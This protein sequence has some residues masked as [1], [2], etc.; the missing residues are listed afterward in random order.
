M[1]ITVNTSNALT[2][3]LIFAGVAD[4]GSFYDATGNHTLTLNGGMS[5][6]QTA[7]GEALGL[8]SGKYVTIAPTLT[9]NGRSQQGGGTGHTYLFV[10]DIGGAGNNPAFVLNSDYQMQLAGGSSIL[11]ARDISLDNGKGAVTLA[12]NIVVNGSNKVLLM[13]MGDQNVP[14]T[15]VY[16]DGV[17]VLDRATGNDGWSSY[18]ISTILGDNQY[19]TANY[20]ASGSNARRLFIWNRMLSDAEMQAVVANVDGLLTGVPAPAVAPT[21][22]SA[23]ADNLTGGGVYVVVSNPL[24]DWTQASPAHAAPALS[25]FT[26]TGSILGAR[27]FTDIAPDLAE[28]RFRL[29]GVSPAFRAGETLTLSYAAPADGSG[30]YDA[31]GTKAMVSFG[32]VTVASNVVAVAPGAPTIGTAQAGDGYVDVVFTPPAFDGYSNLTGYTATLSTGETN[33]GATSPIRVTAANGTARTAH[34]T[35]SNSSGP[36]AASAESNSVTPQA[37]VVA[38]TI[39]APAAPTNITATAGAAGSGQAMVSFT[40]GSDGGA[41]QGFHV[42]ST[43]AN[44]NAGPTA[45]GSTSPI[46]VTGLTAGVAYTFKVRAINSAG[47]SIA[48]GPSNSIT[49]AAAVVTPLPST[50]K[51]FYY[52]P[53]SFRIKTVGPGKDFNSINDASGWLYMRDLVT[54]GSGVAFVVYD[55]E[56]IPGS[57]LTPKTSND[58]IYALWVPAL[59]LSA[60]ELNASGALD[61]GTQG[62]ELTFNGQVSINAGNMVQGFRIHVPA[63]QGGS[64]GGI[65]LG[66][67][68]WS[69]GGS[70]NPYLDSCRILCESASNNFYT[71]GYGRASSISNCVVIQQTNLG[72]IGDFSSFSAT[73]CTFVRRGGTGTAPLFSNRNIALSNCAFA[74]CGSQLCSDTGGNW[75]FASTNATDTAITAGPSDSFIYGATVANAA[76]DL[77]PASGGVLI[78]AASLGQKYTK[79]VRSHN[80]GSSPDIG[81][82][83][84]ALVPDLVFANV[85]QEIVDGQSI[86]V[87]GTLDRAADSATGFMES[88]S[89]GVVSTGIQSIT[90]DNTALT[91][92]VTFDG[93][94]PGTFLPNFT[95]VNAG[96]PSQA[97]GGVPVT[98]IGMTADTVDSGQAGTGTITPSPTAPTI[99]ITTLDV[100]V[101][102]GGRATLNG[103]VNLQGDVTGAV[104]LTIKPAVGSNQGPFVCNVSNGTWTIQKTGLRPGLYTFEVTA[105]ANG[106]TV[107]ATTGAIRVLGLASTNFN[108]PA[109]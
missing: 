6:A 5:T 60:A 104:T 84:L 18:N 23:V 94:L 62:L 46:A 45:D 43:D 57:G 47:Q 44:G 38:P 109:S 15:R 89:Y 58:Q 29:H 93:V 55:N 27:T 53:P 37:G 3:G 105:S 16:L 85:T 14:G 82:V 13:T 52:I 95:F 69:D 99:S 103:T 74:N 107:K 63:N 100:N 81:A 50:A 49:V 61:Y 2:S 25:A 4:A 42:T 68:N 83:Q 97:M 106:Q 54:E 33:T 32:P 7:N 8:G 64:Y 80:R 19:P 72:R 35:A 17:K 11:V 75:G 28:G 78:G 36:G 65:C 92:T 86:T 39:T 88:Q 101:M 102:K 9:W 87:S 76:T 30:L 67:A 22:S 40:P 70:Y 71:G 77:R 91:F 90:L 51:S 79:D 12:D 1:T 96:G 21:F 24:Y 59:G 34:V 10:G 73:G 66:A 98:L 108:M 20:F 26:V 56:T 41:T 48:A 31:T